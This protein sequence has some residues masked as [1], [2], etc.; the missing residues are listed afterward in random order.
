MPLHT[1]DLL[2]SHPASLPRLKT[3]VISR[4]DVSEDF[5]TSLRLFVLA[6]IKI[7]RLGLFVIVRQAQNTRP[8]S[9]SIDEL[10]WLVETTYV[11]LNDEDLVHGGASG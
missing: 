1:L 2:F 5:M 11:V 7:A 4:C 3:L 9:D 6:R 10:S 8:S